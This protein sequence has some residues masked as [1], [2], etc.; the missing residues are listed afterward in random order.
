M[1]CHD[2]QQGSAHAIIIV[3]LV[4]GLI[5]ALGFAY[6]KAFIM[7]SQ[8][9]VSNFAECKTASG[10]KIQESYPEVCVTEDGKRF[11]NPDQHV[12]D[13]QLDT[14]AIPTAYDGWQLTLDAPTDWKIKKESNTTPTKANFTTITSPSGKV[15]IDVMMGEVYLDGVCGPSSV[16]EINKYPTKID[17]LQVVGTTSKLAGGDDQ[18]IVQTYVLPVSGTMFKGLKIGGDPCVMHG[19]HFFTAAGTQYDADKDK[20]GARISIRAVNDLKDG[21]DILKLEDYKAAR[22]IV[23]TLHS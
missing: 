14:Q 8:A 20:V 6:Y 16:T 18:Y 22:Q 13:A 21:R 15:A 3:V 1:K 19:N 11:T 7:Q 23:Q 17:G 4:I 2:K 12:D 10:S 5:G 9:T